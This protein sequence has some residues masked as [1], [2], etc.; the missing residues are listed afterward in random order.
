MSAFGNHIPLLLGLLKTPRGG[1][2][3]I[4][5][6]KCPFCLRSCWILLAYAGSDAFSNIASLLKPLDMM[7]VNVSSPQSLSV[8]CHFI[9]ELNAKCLQTHCK[10]R[11]PLKTGQKLLKV[12]LKVCRPSFLKY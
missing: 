6:E 4:L 9:R 3:P 7:E 10:L 2:G 8:P 1:K 11:T 5:M 12:Y